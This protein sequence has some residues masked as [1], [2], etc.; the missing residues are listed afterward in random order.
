MSCGLAGNGFSV[1]RADPA[2][3]WVPPST[4]TLGPVVADLAALAGYGPDV[5]QAA[6]LDAIFAVGPDN[7]VVAL[8]AAVIACRQNLKTALFKMA[9]LGWLFVTDQRTITWSAHEFP[10]AREAHRDLAELVQNAPSLSRRIKA[11]YYG[12]GDQSIEMK[13]GQRVLFKARTNTG[14]RGLSGDKMVLD[15]AFALT[16]THIGAL[17]PTL[18]AREDPQL[19]YGSSAGQAQ[20]AFLR[21]VRDRGRAGGDPRLA[22]IEYTDDLPG[23][24]SEPACDHATTRQGCRLDE[25]AR[26]ARANPALGRRITYDYVRA[27][28]RAMP[29]AEFARERL[30]WWDEGDGAAIAVPLAVWASLADTN[31]GPPDR[32]TAVFALDVAPDHSTATIAA[33][34][35]RSD[36]AVQL[37][38]ADHQPGVEWVVEF[39]KRAQAKS[40]RSRLL[41][42]TGGTGAFLVPAL[43]QAGVRVEQ[44]PRRFYAE[45]C[46]ALD[47]AVSAGKVRHDNSWPLTE[48][49][50]V[51]RWA[52]SG[53]A[54]QRLLARKDPKVSPLVAAALALHAAGSTVR[55]PGRLMI[56]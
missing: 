50:A 36:G 34:W 55:R 11:V 44:V 47:A 53:E 42:E 49:V 17:F 3:R 21:S 43:E 52:P 6:A 24:C 33:G 45:A 56:F 9:V 14:G 12:A 29:A 13:T 51:A 28:R 32:S 30:G 39:A 25:E 2:F 18:S 37:D 22:Y 26:W 41:V 31:P 10:T 38:V 7:K 4:K 8:E 15:E 20:S 16:D 48:A 19:L 40:P 27:E 54:G 35:R 23:D 5:D 1:L 46:A